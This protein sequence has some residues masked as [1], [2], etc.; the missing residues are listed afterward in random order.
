MGQG[1]DTAGVQ[2]SAA[3]KYFQMRKHVS[4]FDSRVSQP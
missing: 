4:R 3:A 2:I 1:Q